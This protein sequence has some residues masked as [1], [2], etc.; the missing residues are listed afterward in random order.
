[1]HA[2][3]N[4]KNKD[5]QIAYF[6]AGSCH[7][8]DGA[9]SLLC[10]LRE[11]RAHALAM[12]E[13]SQLRQQ[14]RRVR[15][16]AVC[17]MTVCNSENN[18]VFLSS[19]NDAKRLDAEAEL[20]ELD[21]CAELEEINR[22]AAVAELETI[23]KCMALVQLLRRYAHLPDP[24]AHEAAQMEEWR[25]ELIHRAENYLLSGAGLPPDQ[26]A[27]M[28]MHPQFKTGIMPEITR[29]QAAI[30]AGMGE[31][32]LLAPPPLAGLLGQVAALESGV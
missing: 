24:Q 21:A 16:E 2:K 3:N 20:S 7:T 23:D 17:I 5:F 15:A 29:I 22:L 9:Y 4:R 28:R 25:L 10:D 27:T 14:A 26:L 6:L 18:E 32:L 30:A 12:V 1:M 31:A 19:E 11:D 13:S 8:P